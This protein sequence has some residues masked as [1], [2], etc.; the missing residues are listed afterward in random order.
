VNDIEIRNM[1]CED[2]QSVK[3]IYESGIATGVA[4]FETSAP[5]WEKWNSGCVGAPFLV[6]F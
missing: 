1:L 4:T 2:W 6:Q 5:D 3:T